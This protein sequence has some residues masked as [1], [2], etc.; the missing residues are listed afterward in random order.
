MVSVCNDG[1]KVFIRGSNFSYECNHY[2]VFNGNDVANALIINDNYLYCSMPPYLNI[3]KISV[4]IMVN[5]IIVSPEYPIMVTCLDSLKIRN[6]FPSSGSINGGSLV[7]ITLN[8]QNNT[9][10]THCRFKDSV[11]T[12]LAST[13]SQDQVTCM[14]PKQKV[15]GRVA[16]ELSVN[17][18][19][20]ISSKMN[21]LYTM[22]PVVDYIYPISGS[23][24]GGTTVTL[25][26]HNFAETN[27]IR[28][29]FGQMETRGNWI[30]N[31]TMTCITSS[32]NPGERVFAISNNGVDFIHTI[33]NVTFHKSNRQ[34]HSTL[35]MESGG[36]GE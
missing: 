7:T 36:F 21:F 30:S 31:A 19:D 18:V 14:S 12:A 11:V 34:C 17:G 26:G 33:F 6:I 5:K 22:E 13:S 35:C 23:N 28:C 24:N 2:C 3:L 15:P 8:S 4:E 32:S 29:K 27:E 1:V 20:Y 10:I 16:L 9:Y 25:I